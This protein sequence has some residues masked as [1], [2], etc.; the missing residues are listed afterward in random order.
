MDS[1]SVRF[2]VVVTKGVNAMTREEVLQWL[3]E[4]LGI[5]DYLNLG[6]SGAIHRLEWIATEVVCFGKWT[7]DDLEAALRETE[8]IRPIT[9]RIRDIYHYLAFRLPLKR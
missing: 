8:G 4:R 3:S 1:G 7:L 2:A 5:R 9:R 6:D